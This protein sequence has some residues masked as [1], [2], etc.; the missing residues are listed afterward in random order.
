M[1]DSSD[2]QEEGD[3]K[4]KAYILDSMDEEDK[5]DT[6]EILKKWVIW[7]SKDK[8]SASLIAADFHQ[9]LHIKKDILCLLLFIMNR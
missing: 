6:I 5:T 8:W 9:L 1:W 4:E 3:T 2:E 7:K